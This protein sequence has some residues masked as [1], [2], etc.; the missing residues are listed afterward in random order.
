MENEKNNGFVIFRSGVK[1]IRS[2][3]DTADAIR[4]FLAVADYALDGVEPTLEYPLSTFF[5]QIRDGIDSAR[6]KRQQDIESGKR[7]GAKEKFIPPEEYKSCVDKGMGFAA[8]AKHFGVSE[9]TVRSRAKRFNWPVPQKLKNLNSI[10]TEIEDESINK[11][12]GKET[13]EKPSPSPEIKIASKETVAKYAA[14]IN[15]KLS[16]FTPTDPD[17]AAQIKAQ[18]IAALKAIR[19]GA[20]VSE[21]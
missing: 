11:N 8:I 15:E 18:K 1:T 17:K 12:K 14:E 10:D 7:G 5:E 16:P 19:E 13:A 9:N 4:L 21:A 20:E 6:I 3:P 2:V